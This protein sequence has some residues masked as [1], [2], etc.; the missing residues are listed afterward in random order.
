MY[1]QTVSTS[2]SATKLVVESLENLLLVITTMINS[3][4]LAAHF[5]DVWKEALVDP[6]CKKAEVNDFNN[7][8]PVSNLQYVSKLAER[9]VFDQVHAHLSQSVCLQK[10]PWY[11]DSASKDTK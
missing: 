5:P 11:R 7:L 2:T 3:S 6:R 1:C 9:A 8:R 10:G 4:L